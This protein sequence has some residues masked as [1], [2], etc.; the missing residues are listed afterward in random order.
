[1]S[2]LCFPAVINLNSGSDDRIRSDEPLVLMDGH[3]I[4]ICIISIMAA[5]VAV[6]GVFVCLRTSESNFSSFSFRI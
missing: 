6:L 3:L 5:V 2:P 1:M 4:V